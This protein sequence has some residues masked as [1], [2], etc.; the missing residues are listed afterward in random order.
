VQKAKGIKG[1][2]KKRG[3]S[4]SAGA[5]LAMLPTAGGSGE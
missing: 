4:A 3:N 5:R 1:K 2:E